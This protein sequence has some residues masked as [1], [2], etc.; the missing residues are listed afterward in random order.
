MP[1]KR[2]WVAIRVSMNWF[3]QAAAR[4]ATWLS[5]KP[6][7]KILASCV[8]VKGRDVPVPEDRG[9]R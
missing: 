7:N 2:H 3:R 8:E 1:S 9:H 6:I 4:L 5:D